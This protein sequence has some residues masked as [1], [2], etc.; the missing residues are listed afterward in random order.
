MLGDRDSVTCR[1][2]QRRIGMSRFRARSRQILRSAADQAGRGEGADRISGREPSYPESPPR[3]VSTRA[4][5]AR[6][7]QP[8]LGSVR[9]VRRCAGNGWVCRCG[10][11]AI[12]TRSARSLP[13]CSKVTLRTCE[14]LVSSRKRDLGYLCMAGRNA[15]EDCHKAFA[16][17]VTVL[18]TQ[19]SLDGLAERIER[20][21]RRRHSGWFRGCST[22][23]VWSAAAA[24][25]VQLHQEDPTLP[26]DPELYVAVQP[27]AAPGAAFDDPW[28]GLTQAAAARRY[29]KRVREM[30]RG[31]LRRA[32]CRDS[33][34]R[35]SDRSRRGDRQGPRVPAPA[36]FAAGM[37]HRRPPRRSH[38]P[39]GSLPGRCRHAASVLSPVS[40]GKPSMARV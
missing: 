10:L 18:T 14:F 23:R 27:I 20:A 39:G 22:E 4:R 25:L 38:R 13:G 12:A 8:Y 33:L 16:I 3:P 7:G 17:E 36:S 19:A 9:S 28:V 31:L 29:R 32:A 11:R 21:Y 6:S 30:V 37:L 2:A 34:C 1:G 26:L 5:L 35:G 40:S 15:S 24:I